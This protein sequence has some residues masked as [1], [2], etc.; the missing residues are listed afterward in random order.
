MEA[1]A[2]FGLHLESL[3]LDDGS[4]LHH[5]FID[6]LLYIMCGSLL[7]PTLGRKSSLDIIEDVENV[8]ADEN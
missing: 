1:T 6:I 7:L 3:L 4:H 5:H 2:F 8:L